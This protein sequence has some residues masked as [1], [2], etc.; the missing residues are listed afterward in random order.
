[1]I[2]LLIFF[3]S[4]PLAV[5]TLAA[6]FLLVDQN[7]RL[8]ALVHITF[9]IALIAVL[10]VA[11]PAQSRLWIGIAFGVVILLHVASSILLRMGISRG[12]WIT[13]RVE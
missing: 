1:M 9:R 3:L 2:S 5:Y 11:T 8:T 10:L 6:F 4:L 13:D 7:N 12:Y